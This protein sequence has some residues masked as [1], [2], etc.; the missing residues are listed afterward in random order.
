MEKVT[1]GGQVVLVCHP[2]STIS[3]GVALGNGLTLLSPLSAFAKL[4]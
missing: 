1:P 3:G 4:W 2:C